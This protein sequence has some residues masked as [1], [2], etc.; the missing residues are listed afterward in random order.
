MENDQTYYL[1]LLT[2]YFSGETNEEKNR[3]LAEWIKAD[4]ANMNLFEE[5]RSVFHLFS[6]SVIDSATDLDREWEKINSRLVRDPE[7]QK[8]KL[9][10]FFFNPRVIRLAALVIILLIPAYFLVRYLSK[11]GI[12]NLG[13]PYEMVDAVLPD[14]TRVVLKPGSVLEY[15]S[16]FN[17]DIRSVSLKGEGFFSVGHDASRPFILSMGSTRTEDIGTSFYAS[18]N[19]TDGSAKIVLTTG[20]IAV[21]FNDRPSEKKVLEEGDKA[22]ISS[23]QIIVSKNSDV[24]YLAWKTRKIIFEN[25]PLDKIIETLDNVYQADI[26]MKNPGLAGCRLT[27]TFDNQS[28]GSVLNVIKVTLG[29]DIKKSGTFIEISGNGCN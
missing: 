15:P 17:D 13:S 25:D 10:F 3:E 11:P 28:L 26:R 19:S 18:S 8:E 29:L 23:D 2:R 20:R 22:E 5:Y 1:D 14:G 9:S 27:A 6:K 7:P 24:N 21:Y 16:R 12:V 4:P